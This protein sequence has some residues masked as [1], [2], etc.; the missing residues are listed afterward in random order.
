MEE[1]GLQSYL[2]FI[3]SVNGTILRGGNDFAA[4]VNRNIGERLN[5]RV[6]NILSQEEREEIVVP[7]QEWG[8]AG[9]LGGTV[10]Y[11]EWSAESGS[12]LKVLSVVP[13]SPAEAAG[14]VALQDFLLGTD[15]E[16]LTHLDQLAGLV[17]RSQEL[18]IYVYS[19]GEKRVRRVVLR[20]KPGEQLGIDAGQGA[21]HR[22][23]KEE[24]GLQEQGEVAKATVPMESMSA[25]PTPALL[26]SRDPRIPKEPRKTAERVLTN[27]FGTS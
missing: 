25:A 2:D 11:E 8:G 27:P 23:G 20:I 1:G 13:G 5:L 3:L 14:L 10:R 16:S 4:L 12:G 21:I 17:H 24:E 26:V 18:P 7:R 22:L 9:L 6:F 19:S 15:A